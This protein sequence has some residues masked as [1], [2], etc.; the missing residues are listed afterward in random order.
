MSIIFISFTLVICCLLLVYSERFTIAYYLKTKFNRSF[1]KVQAPLL[2]KAKYID[3]AIKHTL[4]I[5]IEPMKNIFDESLKANR[6]VR[7]DGK[8]LELEGQIKDET[9]NY[10]NSKGIILYNH[11][12]EFPNYSVDQ[13]DNKEFIV[14]EFLYEKRFFEL[15]FKNYLSKSSPLK[16]II[17]EL[18]R[19]YDFITFS[20][21]T[22]I[23][24]NIKIK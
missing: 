18:K 17:D 8:V 13:R 20:L 15:Y 12:I 7:I 3:A 9:L 24:S 6:S 23:E 10:M 21:Y 19:E 14:V 22:D 2:P 1:F 5:K 4:K 16:N 11:L